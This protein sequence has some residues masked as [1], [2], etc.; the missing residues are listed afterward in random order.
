MSCPPPSALDPGHRLSGLA[1]A[2]CMLKVHVNCHQQPYQPE[3]A[4]VRRPE[5]WSTRER[6]DSPLNWSSSSAKPGCPWHSPVMP[7]G[8]LTLPTF[9]G[10]FALSGSGRG[11]VRQMALPRASSITHWRQV[12]LGHERHCAREQAAKREQ[13]CWSAFV[14]T[15]GCLFLGAWIGCTLSSTES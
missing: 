14:R 1:D 15:E 7:A 8:L 2:P 13:R 9:A 6:A 12:H 4:G 11:V 5:G 10:G 3:V